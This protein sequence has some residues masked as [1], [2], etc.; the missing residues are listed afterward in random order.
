MGAVGRS[1]CGLVV[2]ADCPLLRGRLLLTA[3]ALGHRLG[4]RGLLCVD[5][6]REN[7]RGRAD[8]SRIEVA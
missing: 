6:A 8:G 2:R 4:G 1:Y 7:E 5:R 3:F